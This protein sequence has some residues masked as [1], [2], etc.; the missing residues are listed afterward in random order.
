VQAA[1][2]GGAGA[3]QLGAKLDQPQRYWRFTVIVILRDGKYPLLVAGHYY[4]RGDVIGRNAE[5]GELSRL[6]IGTERVDL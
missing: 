2:G 1:L 3:V 4:G 5:D 6:L